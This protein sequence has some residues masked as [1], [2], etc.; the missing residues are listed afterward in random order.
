[1]RKK[2][3]K[4]KHYAPSYYYSSKTWS[5]DA[6]AGTSTLRFYCQSLIGLDEYRSLV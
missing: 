4:D 3:T 6:R 1:M 5:S 2:I